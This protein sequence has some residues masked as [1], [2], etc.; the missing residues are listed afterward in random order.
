MWEVSLVSLAPLPATESSFHLSPH[1]TH[2]WSYLR[3]RRC[4]K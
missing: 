2:R 3:R 1:R 4:C